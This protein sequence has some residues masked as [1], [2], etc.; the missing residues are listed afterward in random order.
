[1]SRRT[2]Y[3]ILFAN[4]HISE[5]YIPPEGDVGVYQISPNYELKKDDIVYCSSTLVQNYAL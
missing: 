4:H 2:K 5:A 3:W 1:M